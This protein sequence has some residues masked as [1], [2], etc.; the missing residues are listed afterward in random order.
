MSANMRIGIGYDAHPLVKGRKLVLGGVVI[1][2]AKGLDGW[3]DA[4]V[5][6]HAVMDA[7]LGAAALGDIGRHFPPGDA[8]YKD[9]SSLVLLEKV[10]AKLAEGG[11]GLG[12]IDATVVAEKPQLSEYIDDMRRN[13][14]RVLG[15]DVNRVSIKARSNNGLGDIGKGKGIAVYAVAMIE[16]KREKL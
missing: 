13:L 5:L 6:T 4:D 16:V 3:S 8:Q 10:V 9:V 14:S 2:Y 1:P 11:Y 7:L 12:N 15:I